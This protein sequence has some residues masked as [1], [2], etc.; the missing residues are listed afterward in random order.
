MLL[1]VFTQVA[2]A[3]VY[4][5]GGTT[6][7]NM[8]PMCAN[9]QSKYKFK[10]SKENTATS[11]DG[12]NFGC[13][14]SSPGEQWYYFQA[15]QS[16]SVN[17]DMKSYQDHDYAIWGPYA[18]VASAKNACGVTGPPVDCSYSGS[19]HE[20]ANVNAKAG[21]IYIL[22]VTNYAQIDQ[23]MVLNSDTSMMNC[24]ATE[25]AFTE[26]KA[27]WV[28]AGSPSVTMAGMSPTMPPTKLPWSQRDQCK[29]ELCKQW[30]CNDHD[31]D[32]GSWC[33]CWEE[34]VEYPL[35]PEVDDDEQCDCSGKMS[36]VK[37]RGPPVCGDS[38]II[39]GVDSKATGGG[40]GGWTN[41]DLK[42]GRMPHA[43]MIISREFGELGNPMAFQLTQ[44][45]NYQNKG[46][47]GGMQQEFKLKP[48]QEYTLKFDCCTQGW[49]SELY[50][51]VDGRYTRHHVRCNFVSPGDKCE[52]KELKFTTESH[53]NNDL[54]TRN[55]QFWSDFNQA[56]CPS[57]TNI[58]LDTCE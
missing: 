44:A 11:N 25:M 18:S 34:G 4:L 23:E 22:V 17:F 56:D 7:K 14:A 15:S 35:C 12:Q 3:Q 36:G 6:C 10:F 58:V 55:I 16:G 21:E 9:A 2:Q 50:V 51:S 30:S 49:G 48:E 54:V 33:A 37:E 47:Q 39:S 32:V 26:A 27:A 40:Y 5:G 8:Q 20:H 28:A 57:V 19:A 43:N 41:V 42:N 31:R 13:L 38:G 1:S 29:P 53:W 45:C 46:H 24:D 52:P